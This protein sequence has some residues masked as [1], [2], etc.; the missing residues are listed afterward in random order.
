MFSNG[1]SQKWAGQTMVYPPV[2][3]LWFEGF[4]S[5][6][7]NVDQ[8][9]ISD[10]GF[11]NVIMLRRLNVQCASGRWKLSAACFCFVFYHIWNNLVNSHHKY[12]KYYKFDFANGEKEAGESS[13]GGDM[14]I[15]NGR[16]FSSTKQIRRNCGTVFS[17]A[18]AHSLDL[19]GRRPVGASNYGTNFTKLLK[20]CEVRIKIV[21]VFIFI[22]RLLEVPPCHPKP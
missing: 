22:P 14:S 10:C 15:S 1:T 6:I 11:K 4:C 5:T 19:F 17:V 3:Y 8:V 13:G 9:K 18:A 16:K 21:F 2:L 20:K 12:I 7:K